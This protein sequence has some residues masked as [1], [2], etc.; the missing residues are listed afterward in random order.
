M[1]FFIDFTKVKQK[2]EL[3]NKT[4]ENLQSIYL[5]LHSYNVIRLCL[6]L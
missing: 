1:P 6:L 3:C 4:K 5:S 2:K